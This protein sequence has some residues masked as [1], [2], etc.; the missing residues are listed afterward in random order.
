MHQPIKNIVF[1]SLFFCALSTSALAVSLD[2]E[3]E[4]AFC[5]YN[6]KV[7]SVTLKTY[8]TQKSL[9]NLDGYC[10]YTPGGPAAACPLEQEPI[11][12]TLEW[13]HDKNLNLAT[14][15]FSR[16]G[17]KHA[18]TSSRCTDNPWTNDNVSCNAFIKNFANTQFNA[19]KGPYPISASLMSPA[20]KQSLKQQEAQT[21]PIIIAPPAPQILSPV[22]NQIFTTPAKIK[23]NVKHD[24]AYTAVFEFKWRSKKPKPGEWPE[25]YSVVEGIVPENV[26]QKN[27]VTTADLTIGK[28][29][30]WMIRS[31]ASFP[32]AHWREVTFVVVSGTQNIQPIKKFIPKLKKLQ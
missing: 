20:Q 1:L 22:N 10:Y 23:I 25:N 24:P 31:R 18:N 27:G 6:C 9:Y 17:H 11:S 16:G 28:A 19:F 32:N 2:T 29:G 21:T 3:G 4:G 12:G 13:I 7:T 15:I 5:V 8:T 26:V 30:Q 14:E